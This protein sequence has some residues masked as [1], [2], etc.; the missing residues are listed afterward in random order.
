M[1]LNS[2]LINFKLYSDHKNPRT[3]SKLTDKINWFAPLFL[4]L[5]I[6]IQWLM[7]GFLIIGLHPR[8]RVMEQLTDLGNSWFRPEYDI[9]IYIIGCFSI[10]LLTFF[11]TWIWRR[12]L[13]LNAKTTGTDIINAGIKQIYSGSVSFAVQTA[14][15]FIFKNQILEY[16][17]QPGFHNWKVVLT[18]F[19]S[20]VLISPGAISL[21]VFFIQTGYRIIIIDIFFR[22]LKLIF[23]L[24]IKLQDI[25]VPSIIILLIYIPDWQNISGS[26]FMNDK[27]FHWDV[28]AI[29]QALAFKQGLIP[30]REIYVQYGIGWPV[31]L[32]KLYSGTFIYGQAIRAG[33]IYA[34]CYYIGVYILLRLLTKSSLWSLTGIILMLNFQFFMIHSPQPFLWE[35]P[36]STVLRMPMDIWFFICLY[37]YTSTKHGYWIKIMAIL[38]GLAILFGFDTGLYLLLTHLLWILFLI[39]RKKIKSKK[40]EIKTEIKSILTSLFIIII[41]VLSG[42]IIVGKTSV[43]SSEFW[44]GIFEG[45]IEHGTGVSAYP[46][47]LLRSNTGLI[48]FELII[49]TYL[50][51]LGNV[52]IKILRQENNHDDLLKA[53]LSFYGLALLLIFVNRSKALNI[54]HPSLP[55]W[56]LMTWMITGT[57]KIWLEQI[58]NK[59]YINRQNIKKLFQLWIPGFL[60]LFSSVILFTGTEFRTYPNLLNYLTKSLPV[61]SSCL[62]TE[63]RDICGLP[64]TQKQTIIDFDKV[65]SAVKILLSQGKTVAIFDDRDTLFNLAAGNTTWFRYQPGLVLFKTQLDTIKRQIIQQPTDYLLITNTDNGSHNVWNEVH[66]TVDG[67]YFLTQTIG[68]MEFWSLQKP[69][70]NAAGY[71]QVSLF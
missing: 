6:G 25:I 58:K 42:L 64:D 71:L 30:G 36:S 41:V 23:K 52:L 67:R 65:V 55:F 54:L 70:N 27:F 21:A 49:G 4:S 7:A 2:R 66:K 53:S 14:L 34:C 12:Y 59:F 57:N 32:S 43:F 37:F 39:I 44:L 28:F 45:V 1:F 31:L 63:P 19:W 62:M 51:V 60:L 22:Q 61:K 3:M 13:Q 56:I 11:L 26:I 15:I 24:I 40:V 17:Q 47:A 35:T 68:G 9:G 8:K 33:I 48:G 20:L 18:I 5:S 16:W 29:R 69:V 46:M 10:L 50:M 38:V